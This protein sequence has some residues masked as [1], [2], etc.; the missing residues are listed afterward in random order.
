MYQKIQCVRVF[1][2]KKNQNINILTLNPRK[3]LCLPCHYWWWISTDGGRGKITSAAD[4][5]LRFLQT[6]WRPHLS[7]CLGQLYKREMEG[8]PVPSSLPYTGHPST[9]VPEMKRFSVCSAYCT[10]FSCLC[11]GPNSQ[12]VWHSC[13][14]ANGSVLLRGWQLRLQPSVLFLGSLACWMQRGAL[15]CSMQPWTKWCDVVAMK[16]TRRE[17]WRGN[18]LFPGN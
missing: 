2:K 4:K 8:T 5:G 14:Q 7:E 12:L 6:L 17:F 10:L 9:A 1:L 3:T 18:A 11:L 16:L 13:S 15:C